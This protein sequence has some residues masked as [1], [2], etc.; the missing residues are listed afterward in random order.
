MIVHKCDVCHAEM[1]DGICYMAITGL[2]EWWNGC[3]NQLRGQ[4]CLLLGEQAVG[5]EICPLCHQGL[6]TTLGALISHRKGLR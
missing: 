2:E 5:L 1:S 4:E 6:R 3:A